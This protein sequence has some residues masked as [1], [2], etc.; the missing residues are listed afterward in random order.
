MCKYF[1]VDSSDVVLPSMGGS[2]KCSAQQAECLQRKR[3]SVRWKA[4]G[5]AGSGA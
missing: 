1:G 2:V 4:A 3:S 5:V